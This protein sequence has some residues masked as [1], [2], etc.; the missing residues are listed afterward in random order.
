MTFYNRPTTTDHNH[1][2]AIDA[3]YSAAGLPKPNR[4][5][6]ILKRLD[7]AE[8]VDTVAA[9]LARDLIHVDGS[10]LDKALDDALTELGRASNAAT[11][12]THVG[13]A[14][15]AY[16]AEHIDKWVD[17]AATDLQPVVARLSRQ[18]AKAAD[19]LPENDPFSLEAAV[20]GD[21]TKEL[22]SAQQALRTLGVLAG[23]HR[24]QYHD[25]ACP[26][27]LRPVIPLVT[28]PPTEPFYLRVGGGLSGIAQGAAP[29]AAVRSL[30]RAVQTVGADVALLQVARGKYRDIRIELAT[31]NAL[32]ERSERAEI[33]YQTKRVQ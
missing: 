27:W 33:A 28:I 1:A 18:L 5:H 20:E 29:A 30:G 4:R 9:R 12:R 25:H 19:T 31:T 10:D 13:R 3:A 24:G 16:A 2:R 23:I 14:V 32:K 8:T 11:L 6:A 15:D 7:Q 22:K 21:H 26:T 17:Q